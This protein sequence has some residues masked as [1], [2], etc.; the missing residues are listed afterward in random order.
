MMITVL[1]IVL[2]LAIISSSIITTITIIIYYCYDYYCYYDD[3]DTVC[4]CGRVSY[5]ACSWQATVGS[6]Q[7]IL[8]MLCT[9]VLTDMIT[10]I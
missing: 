7:A 4:L 10:Q 9:A 1:T 2:I 3:H 8:E 6:I 5:L